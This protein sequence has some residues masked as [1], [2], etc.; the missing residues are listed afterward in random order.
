MLSEI[1]ETQSAYK[2]TYK[3]PTKKA[4]KKERNM[5]KLKNIKKKKKERQKFYLYFYL[6]EIQE[7]KLVMK[8]SQTASIDLVQCQNAQ[9]LSKTVIPVYSWKCLSI[10]LIKIVRTVL[11][12]I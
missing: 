7:T 12:L 1:T 9:Q 5:D 8:F 10:S 4:S 11:D 3:Q 2:H 6:L